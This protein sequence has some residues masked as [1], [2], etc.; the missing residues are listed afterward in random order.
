[1]ASG[2]KA[3]RRGNT[4]FVGKKLPDEARNT[5]TR[6]LRLNQAKAE[7]VATILASQGAEFNL[8][9]QPEIILDTGKTTITGGEISITPPTAPVKPA[10]TLT[11]IKVAADKESGVSYLLKDLLVSIDDRLNSLTLVGEPRQVELATS[12]VLQMDSRRRQVSINVKIVD[13]NLTNTQ[14]Q[15]TKARPA[16]SGD[17]T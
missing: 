3:S 5:V 1:M 8:L 14:T 6:T 4:L 13:V 7:N 9:T 11:S 17:K 10:P 12:I 15:S 16:K 2:L